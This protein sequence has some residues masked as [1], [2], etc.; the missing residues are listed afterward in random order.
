[1]P[2]ARLPLLFLLSVLAAPPAA[3]QMLVDTLFTWRGYAHPSRCRV[4]IF[5]LPEAEERPHTIVL[6]ELAENEGRS[7]VADA[8]HVAELVGR[9]FGLRPEATT[10][11][12]HWGAFSYPGAAPG[13]EK[14]LLL[15]ATF[16]RTKSGS[17]STPSWRVLTRDDLEALTDRHLR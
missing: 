2:S 11:V 1:M 8:Q 3:G 14:E 15:R 4:R 7:T 5:A 16:R 10:W 6:Q 17:L 12:F 13:R 9:H